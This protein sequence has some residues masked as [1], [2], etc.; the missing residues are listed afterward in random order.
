MIGDG[1][2]LCSLARHGLFLFRER[3]A[4]SG[5]TRILEH[6]EL[7]ML[8]VT[9]SNTM[10]ALWFLDWPNFSGAFIGV[11]APGGGARDRGY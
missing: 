3:R 8:A 9:L 11:P 10:P 5:G 4:R 6:G 7:L 2:E 1:V